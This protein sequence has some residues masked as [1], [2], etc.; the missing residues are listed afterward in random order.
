LT[1]K[2]PNKILYN[3]QNTTPP[4]HSLEGTGFLFNRQTTS[5]LKC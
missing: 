2:V 5:K 3:M 1:Y 4:A